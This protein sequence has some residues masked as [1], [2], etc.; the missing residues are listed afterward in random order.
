LHLQGN[1]E[2]LAELKALKAEQVA[3]RLVLTELV[4]TTT[5]AALL[6]LLA[7]QWLFES[8]MYWCL[9]HSARCDLSGTY[10]AA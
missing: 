3:M 1:D 7:D 6:Y 8:W 4:S 10:T 9:P 2:V 5:A